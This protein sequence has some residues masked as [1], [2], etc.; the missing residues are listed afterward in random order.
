MAS[1]VSTAPGFG[2]GQ[3]F[4]N[5]HTLEISFGGN[6]SSSPNSNSSSSN[7]PSSSSSGKDEVGKFF[8]PLKYRPILLFLFSKIDF[9]LWRAN[10][11]YIDCQNS[12]VLFHIFLKKTKAWK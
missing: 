7:G 11:N 10:R 3:Q 9:P 6:G 1:E 5:P 8:R 2:T 4:P 12:I